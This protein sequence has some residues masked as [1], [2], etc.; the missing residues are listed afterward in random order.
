MNIAP[1]PAFQDNYIWAVNAGND[2]MVID[3]GDASVVAHW[4]EQTGYQLKFILITHHHA[5][6]TAGLLALKERYKTTVYGPDEDIKGVDHVLMGDELLDLAS[7]G[8]MKIMAIPGHTRA[9]IAYYLPQA[10][11]LFCGDTLFSAGCGRI[12]EGTAQQMHD[13]LSLLATLPDN[14]QVCCTHEYTASN[15]RFAL[16]VE[17]DN[18]A[19]HARHAEV[20]T[21]RAQ[22]QPSLPSTLKL[23]K[24]TNPFLRSSEQAVIQAATSYA[25]S[26]L[27]NSLAVF[28]TLR[29]WKDVFRG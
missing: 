16:T 2:A 19:L 21:L 25:G 5:D 24:S 28:T 3:P 4:L 13:S 18:Q 29:Q 12:F 1:L 27:K 23:E 20:T 22:G 8:T 7:F 11:L 14:T 6:H 17:P 9:H 10:S 15:L 26:T